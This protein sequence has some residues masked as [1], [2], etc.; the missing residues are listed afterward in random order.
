MQNLKN[1]DPDLF[2]IMQDEIH[3]QHETL[4]MIA[5]ENFV[6]LAV[7][8]TLGSV[9]TNK[10]AEG[11]PSKRYYGGCEHVDRAENLARERARTLFRCEYINVQPHSGSQANM[12]AYMSFVSTGD[13]ILGMNLSHGGHLTHGSPVNFSGQLY[14]FV[15]YGVKKE[16]GTIDFDEVWKQARTHRPKLIVTGASAYPRF[17]DFSKFREI[18][19]EVGAYLMADIAHPAGLIA[20]QLHPDPLPYCD[21]VTTTTHKTLRGPRGGMILMGK[22]RENPMGITAAKSGRTKMMS[23]IIDSA[24]MPGIQGGPLM[25][26]IA[27]KAVAFRENLSPDYL[28]YCRQI[29]KN[30]QYLGECLVEQGYHL[31]SG[32]TD[33]H[34]ILLDLSRKNITGKEAEKTLEKAGITVNKNMIP[35]DEKSPMITSGVRIGT[36]ALT[37]RGMKEPEMKRIAGWIH[38]VLTSPDDETLRNRI[39]HE[40]RSLCQDFP[41]YQELMED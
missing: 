10:Y 11:Y 26:V 3:R 7:L 1:S 35:F 20:M 8:E 16:T 9:M 25:H 4:E 31:V 38:Q 24:V 23:E 22:D 29:I 40:I 17:I 27:A 15:S 34:L 5:S 18:A 36:A 39:R 6:S 19:D 13:T 12:A 28:T 37:T 32:G 41:L 33:N 30:T 21:I 2:H 14:H